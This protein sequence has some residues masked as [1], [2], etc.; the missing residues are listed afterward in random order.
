VPLQILSLYFQW[1][2]RQDNRTCSRHSFL[3]Q[4]MNANGSGTKW[5]IFLEQ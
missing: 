3:H 2:L 4:R 5:F 1:R